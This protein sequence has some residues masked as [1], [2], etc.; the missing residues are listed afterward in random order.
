[1]AR[2][3]SGDYLP[4]CALILPKI[5]QMFDLG[6][7]ANCAPVNATRKV[8]IINPVGPAT[9]TSESKIAQIQAQDMPLQ[10][11]SQMAQVSTMSLASGNK[12]P[13]G[14]RSLLDLMFIIAFDSLDG[15]KV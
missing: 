4:N 3:N 12:D 5:A 14:M 8:G 7:N 15:S 10:P 1:M 13:L 6:N 9:A 2:D 11:L